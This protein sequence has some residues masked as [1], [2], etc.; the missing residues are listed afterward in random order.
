M[1]EFEEKEVSE[2]DAFRLEVAMHEEVEEHEPSDQRTVSPADMAQ[3]T[4]DQA[5]VAEVVR[6]II[7]HWVEDD[8]VAAEKVVE[9]GGDPKFEKKF[10]GLSDMNAQPQGMVGDFKADSAGPDEGIDTPPNLD[11]GEFGGGGGGGGDGDGAAAQWTDDGADLAQPVA[12]AQA[13][14]EEEP[15]FDPSG[16]GDDDDD[17]PK[18]KPKK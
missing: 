14:E 12:A 6:D 13:P 1:S 18:N 7:S 10:A 3:T 8:E 17:K 2:S 4:P 9:S 16:G 5:P 11:G 15:G